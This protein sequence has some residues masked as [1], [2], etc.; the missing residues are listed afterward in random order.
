MPAFARGLEFLTIYL[1]GLS[2]GNSNSM[3]DFG[4]WIGSENVASG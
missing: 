4:R 1:C 3:I 2:V